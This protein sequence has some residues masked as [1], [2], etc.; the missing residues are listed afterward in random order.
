M[1]NQQVRD[2]ARKIVSESVI[3]SLL[4]RALTVCSSTCSCHLSLDAKCSSCDMTSCRSE[5]EF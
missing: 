1:R 3:A 4:S 2:G 5:E